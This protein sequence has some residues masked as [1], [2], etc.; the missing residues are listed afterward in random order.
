M[1]T[2]T[3]EDALTAS[4]RREVLIKCVAQLLLLGEVGYRANAAKQAE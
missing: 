4:F 3:P 2:G 1:Y